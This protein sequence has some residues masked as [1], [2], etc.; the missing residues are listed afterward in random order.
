[1]ETE[2]TQRETVQ[3]VQKEKTPE[4]KYIT[5]KQYILEHL[6]SGFTINQMEALESYKCMRLASVIW[7]LRQAGHPI[8]TKFIP[9]GKIGRAFA[10]YRLFTNK[11]EEN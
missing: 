5:Q 6:Q 3:K 2:T 7:L 4:A 10:E 11:V 8:G 9:T 1:M